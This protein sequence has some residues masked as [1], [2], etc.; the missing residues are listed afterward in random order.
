MAALATAALLGGG[1]VARA[2][3]TSNNAWLETGD[4]YHDNLTTPNLPYLVDTSR[5][6]PGGPDAALNS[7]FAFSAPSQAGSISA[8]GTSVALAA[9]QFTG[10]PANSQFHALRNFDLVDQFAGGFAFDL[11]YDFDQVRRFAATDARS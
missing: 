11:G 7:S 3:T 6:A 5:L 9:P 1:P 10:N 4:S 8:S 2:M